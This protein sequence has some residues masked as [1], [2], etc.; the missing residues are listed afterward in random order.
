[1]TGQHAVSIRLLEG[2]ELRA[3]MPALTACVRA[4]GEASPSRLPGWLHVLAGG[5]GHT[6]YCLEALADDGSTEGLLPLAWVRSLLFGRY[7]VGLPY[8]NVGGVMADDACVAA[9]LIDRAVDLA[10]R[11]DVR[12]LELRHERPIEHEALRHRLETKVHMRLALPSA[13]DAL[14]RSFDPKVR[15]QVRKAEKLGLSVHTAGEELLPEFYDVFA[16][17]MRDLG[18]PV[19]PRRL[20][21]AI[22]RQFPGQAELRVVRQA[23]RPIAAAIV[24]HGNGMTEVPSASSLRRYNATCANMLLYWGLLS[25][26]IERGQRV[27]DFGRSSRASGTYRFKRQWGAEPHPAVWQY[28]VR[29]G[30]IGDLRRESGRYGLMIR[31]WQRL[32]VALTRLIGPPIVRGIP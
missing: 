13:A 20:F 31:L 17:N 16:T 14:W 27:F 22:L 6:P 4:R 21:R 28:A 23:D 24:V 15:N 7:L 8:L 12:H 25:S 5:L 18:T 2:A 32:P 19:F 1:M 10:A 11:L 30:S 9:A 26:A 29:R 3:R